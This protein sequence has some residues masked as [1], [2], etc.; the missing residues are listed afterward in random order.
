VHY[1]NTWYLDAWCHR[2]HSLRVFSLDAME[3]VRM[4]DR[5]AHEIALAEVESLLGE[6]Y[7]IYRGRG[8]HWAI[9]RFS[10]N[11]ARWVRA[12]VWHPRQRS[13][14]LDDGRYELRV[15]Y[16]NSAELEMDILRHGEHVEVV[17]PQALRAAVAERLMSAAR[18]YDVIAQESDSGPG[19]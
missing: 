6:G 17:G 11:A 15:P 16:A 13:R 4:L 8:L 7:G 10:E 19:D 1:R 3:R 12:E 2:S 18:H 14:V 9:L 5:A